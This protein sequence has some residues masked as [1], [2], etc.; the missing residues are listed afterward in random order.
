MLAVAPGIFQAGGEMR[1]HLLLDL[2]IY[3][4]KLQYEA[5]RQ[6]AGGKESDETTEKRMPPSK[7]NG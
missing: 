7:S 1:S 5:Q 6:Q 3:I 4:G 2:P